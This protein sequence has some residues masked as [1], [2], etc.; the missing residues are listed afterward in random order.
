MSKAATELDTVDQRLIELLRRDSRQPVLALSR[1]VGLSRS[2]VQDRIA[3]LKRSGV[4]KRFTVDTNDDASA[5]GARAFFF[6][7][8]EGRPCA[9]VIPSLTGLPEVESCDHVSG[10]MDVVLTVRAP[11]LQAL[12]AL[13]E[14]IVAMP[15]IATVTVAPVLK[16][17][18]EPRK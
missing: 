6:V 7:R 5:T 3:R 11:D 9:R 15:G 12:S 14:R 18:L 4:I 1:A 16:S 13:R 10:Q 17:H 8:I 2:T